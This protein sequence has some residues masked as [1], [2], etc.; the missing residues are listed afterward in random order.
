MTDPGQG[1]MILYSKAD[2]APTLSGVLIDREALGKVG[3]LHL[4]AEY[5]ASG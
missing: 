1:C 3:G 2:Q 4:L 5:T